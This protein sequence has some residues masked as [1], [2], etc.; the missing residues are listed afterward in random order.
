VLRK[1]CAICSPP[2]VCSPIVA[3]ELEFY[4]T[5]R[6]TD[7]NT[8]LRPPVGRSGRAET[9]R[10]AYSI[11]AVNEFD[12]LFEEIYDYSDKMELERATP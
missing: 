12:P 1:V 7:P 5:A 6:N 2:K 4:L 3:P 9:S 8:L 10:Q 11:D